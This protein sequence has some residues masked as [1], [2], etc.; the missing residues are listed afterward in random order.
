MRPTVMKLN[1]LPR[2]SL[3]GGALTRT[4]VRSARSL[5]TINWIA[6]GV[7][8]PPPH[9]HPFDQL[10]FIFAGTM[11]FQIDGEE[12]ELGPGSAILIPPDA[13]HT[14]W[15]I[16]SDTVLNVDV[17]APAREDYLFLA[18]HQEG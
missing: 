14:A 3:F 7:P 5:V 4:A 18:D 8:R 10:S 1:D 15:P 9:H 11:I 17:F 2:E 13:P 12:F 16:G 6:P